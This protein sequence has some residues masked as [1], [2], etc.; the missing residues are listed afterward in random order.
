ME[1]RR[2]SRGVIFLGG[3]GVRSPEIFMDLIRSP[4]NRGD[5]EDIMGKN[6]ANNEKTTF[7]KTWFFP[8]F[9]LPCLL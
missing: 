5:I 9:L 3:V 4:P 8:F 1:R 6:W 2:K 7:S